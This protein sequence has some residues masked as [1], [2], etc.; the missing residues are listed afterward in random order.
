MFESLG[1]GWKMIM[2]SI[3]MGFEDKRLL[4]PSLAT[5]FVN[6]FFG[7]LLMGDVAKGFAGG[8]S[9]AGKHVLRGSH[10]LI[11][12]LGN[13]QIPHVGS[14]GGMMDQSGMGSMFGNINGEVC[15]T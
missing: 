2:A 1:R 15:W 6:F 14:M 9:E 13:G 4:L 12:S 7:L 8:G 5:V 3:R 10:N 11:Q